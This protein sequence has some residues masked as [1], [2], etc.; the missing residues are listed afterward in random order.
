M[1]RVALFAE[2]SP[3]EQLR[4]LTELRGLS[5]SGWADNIAGLGVALA[6]LI[7]MSSIAATILP[8][9]YE[10]WPREWGT[11]AHV[12][13]VVTWGLVIVGIAWCSLLVARDSNKRAVTSS[14]A[15]ALLAAYED[16]LA[17]REAAKGRAAREW[18]RRHPIRWQERPNRRATA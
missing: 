13:D 17:R 4:I 7:G 1:H 3:E 16:E 15:R 11:T 2:K 9:S 18:R 6:F 10:T 14:R 12:L 5:G 8:G